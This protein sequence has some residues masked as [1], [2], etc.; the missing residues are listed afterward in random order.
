M[1]KTLTA[2]LRLSGMHK[3]K[4]NNIRGITDW[5]LS[6]YGIAYVTRLILMQMHRR[7]SF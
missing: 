1:T 4:N 3:Y 2:M 7:D 5:I 6:N